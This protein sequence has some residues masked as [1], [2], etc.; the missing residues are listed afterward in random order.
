MAN[1][2]ETTIAKL[3]EEIEKP[4]AFLD[5]LKKGKI[6]EPDCL[7]IPTVVAKSKGTLPD[8]KGVFPS[9]EAARAPDKL[10]CLLYADVHSH[11]SM[12]AKLSPVDDKDEKATRL[13]IVMGNLDRFFPS[14][15]ARVSC[16]GTQIDIDPHLVIES[17]GEEFTVYDTALYP[18]FPTVEPTEHYTAVANTLYERVKQVRY[19]NGSGESRHAASGIRFEGKHVWCIDGIR[20]A[21]SDDEGSDTYRACFRRNT[22]RGLIKGR[23][24]K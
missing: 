19:A 7:V 4:K 15:T 24:T 1:P 11:N 2:K 3:K 23:R 21:L 5:A 12:P 17:A 20:L 8:Y 13:Y 14:I 9:V 6:K 22:G 18:E 10:I 16:G